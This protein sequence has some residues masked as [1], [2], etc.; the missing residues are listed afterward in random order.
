MTTVPPPQLR[1]FSEGL[2]FALDPFQVRAC[3]ALENGH[4]V[5]VCAPTGAGK[6]IVGEFAVHL[7]LAAGRKCFY[8][9]PIKALSNQKH[10]DLVSV[11]GPEKVGL[12]TG[13]SSINSDAPVVV[14]TTEVLRNMLYADS[15]A[16][17]GLSYVVMDEVHFLADRFRGAVWEEVILHLP[18]DVALA[19]LSATVSN[20]EEFGGWIKTVRGDTT[21][22]VDETRPVPLWQHVMVGRRLFDLFD[23]DEPLGRRASGGTGNPSRVDPGLTRY[24]AQRRQADRFADFDRPRR[25]GPQQRTSRPPTLYRPPS[26]P[27]VITRLDEDGLLPAITFIFSRAGCDGAVAQC[28][29]SR[30]RLTTE[31]ERR[32]IIA[33]ID[34]RT[35]GLPEADLDVLGYWQWREGLLRGIAAH[36]AG[37]LPVFRHTV[38]ELFTKGL[39][40]AVF[41]T[42][43]LALGINMPARTVVLERLVKF[44]GE[45]HAALTPGEYTQLTGRAGRR[46]IDVEGHAVVLWTPEVEPTE[47]AGLASTRTFPLRSSFAPSYN[48]TI[49][50][51]HR[52]GPDPARELLERSFAQYQA[53][54]SVVGLVRGIERGR[55]ML[56]EIAGE[57]DGHDGSVLQYVRLRAGLTERER[58]AA[59]ASRLERR[60]AAN[61]ALAA[62]KRGD[63][64]AIPHG[65]RNGVAVVLEPAHDDEDPR[66]LVLTEHR[67]AGRISSADYSG[68]AEPLGSIALPKRVEHRQPKVRRDVASALR[69]ALDEGRVRRPQPG[70]RRT[71]GRHGDADAD[72]ER[73]RREI[74]EHPVHHAPNREELARTGERYLRIERDNAQ[75]QKKVA[76]ATNSLARTFDRILALLAERGYVEDS[77]ELGMKVTQDG[78][79]LARIYSESDLLVAECLRRGLWAGLKPAEL[80]A[81]ASAVLYES[82]GDTVS[83]TGEAPTAALRGALAET[84][85]ALARLRRDE[86]QHHLSPTREIDEGFVAAVYL[87]ATTGDLAASLEAAGDT[88]TALPAGDFV[89]WCRQV[90]DLLDQ[91][92]KAAPDAEVRSAAKAAVGDVRRGVVA[93]D[94]T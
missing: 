25:R 79:L 22:V 89:R 75:L 76:A 63:V 87:W 42:E 12:L 48:M 4:G 74:R 19:S 71:D 83:A 9:T 66:P 70:K 59:R 82:R 34:R 90:V 88:G 92:H 73:L 50:L 36:H 24:I 14:M 61:D 91:I 13:D 51:V 44:N 31:E 49:N 62:L 41:A 26:R 38:E 8:T 94:G 86:Q 64:I 5:L 28:L 37:M 65:R 35:E 72:L 40:K 27:E 55:K 16:L 67:W 18:E 21:V 43:T 52:M 3:T 46:G 33:I 47:I 7:A 11:Y 93:V 58:A 10:N 69:S 32:E 84:H 1:A 53:D 6:T 23:G 56:D 80:A 78:M 60:G 30:L 81:V 29:R 68:G 77:A 2:S 20:A 39:V 54:R 17:H 45:Q 57:L 85:R 15:P